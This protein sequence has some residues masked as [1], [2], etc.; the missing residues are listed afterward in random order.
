MNQR[1]VEIMKNGEFG[2][3]ES[4][5]DAKYKKE[6]LQKAN[7]SYKDSKSQSKSSNSS[8]KY[9]PS[10]VTLPSCRKSDSYSDFEGTSQYHKTTHSSGGAYI[11]GRRWAWVAY[12]FY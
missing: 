4:L 11:R 12:A 5:M 1:E 6:S 9:S 10:Y 2:Q 8:S 7:S 3:G